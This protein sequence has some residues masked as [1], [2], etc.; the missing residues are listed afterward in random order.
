MRF[1]E[2]NSGMENIDNCSGCGLHSWVVILNASMHFGYVDTWL[3]GLVSVKCLFIP[4]K[5]FRIH[6]TLQPTKWIKALLVS[7][8][9]FGSL[10]VDI[11]IFGPKVHDTRHTYIYEI[12]YSNLK[13]MLSMFDSH[14]KM[15]SK[16]IESQ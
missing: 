7:M 4:R 16:R 15:L 6:P 3:L 12:Q 13:C 2:Y 10:I 5:P 14:F 1:S 9:L 8:I 11:W